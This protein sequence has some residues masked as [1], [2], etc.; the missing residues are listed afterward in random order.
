MSL[1]P[2]V[3]PAKIPVR[4]EPS[5]AGK[6]PVKLAAGKFVKLAPLPENV[7]A[8]K[9]PFDELNVK[10]L[11]VLG[12]KLPVALVVNTGKQVVSDDSLPTVIL[13]AVAAVPEVSWF[14]AVLTPGRF[15]LAD[16]SKLTPAIVLAVVN[17]AADPVVF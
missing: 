12:G 15:I 2:P 17:V 16:P 9:V 13:V 11:T 4:F 14:P 5:I 3:A 8:P 7:V 10:L 1:P 6:V